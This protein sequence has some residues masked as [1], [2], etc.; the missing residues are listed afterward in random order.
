[1]HP[2]T[3]A[4]L[5]AVARLS[6]AVGSDVVRQA[7]S[8]RRDRSV[9]AARGAFGAS[10]SFLAALVIALLKAEVSAPHWAVIVTV[11][12]SGVLMLGSSLILWR[13]RRLERSYLVAMQFLE[14]FRRL[15]P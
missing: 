8:W 1:M 2:L 13:S 11:A 14:L 15:F 4:D 10:V 12:S 9:A 6:E 7:Y 5:L 3:L